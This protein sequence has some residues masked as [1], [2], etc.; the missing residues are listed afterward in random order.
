M[1]QEDAVRSSRLDAFGMRV[2]VERQLKPW[3]FAAY[4]CHV[5]QKLKREPGG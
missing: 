3:S 2:N 1:E 5:K 4:C